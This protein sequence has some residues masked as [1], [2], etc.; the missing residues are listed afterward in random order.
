MW[1]YMVCRRWE[2]E[3]VSS[4]VLLRFLLQFL[5]WCCLLP[6]KLSTYDFYSS[7][8]NFLS[9][10]AT[11]LIW[12]LPCQF[13]TGYIFFIVSSLGL[14]N[15]TVS[16]QP[17]YE[18]YT[19]PIW[20]VFTTLLVTSLLNDLIIYVTK[21]SLYIV[22]FHYW[23]LFSLDLLSLFILAILNCAGQLHQVFTLEF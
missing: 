17:L 1:I 13:I 3:L 19:L 4:R 12:S 6:R 9:L 22:H 15:I 2:W 20:K 21:L 23:I 8:F 7:G 14:P 16:R 18:P 11:S 10:K 5:S